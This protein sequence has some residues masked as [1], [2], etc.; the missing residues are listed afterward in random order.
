MSMQ[1]LKRIS[2]LRAAV[3]Q[4]RQA[5]ASIGL[6]PTMGALH[7]GHGALMDRAR[8]ESGFVVVT[9]FV[10]P[11][12]FDRSSDYERYSR[13]LPADLEFCQARG[14]ALVFAP[15]PDEIY[16][17]PQRVF[18]EA[19]SLAEHLCG[20]HR[21]GHFR[22]VATVVTKLF[23]VV[24]PDRAY[25][26]EKDAQ[27]LAIIEALVADL[28]MPITIV[29]V[30]TVR[31]SDGLA[32]S[33]RNTRLSAGER[34]QAAALY[35]ALRAVADKIAA[36]T[37]P[38]EAKDAG[39]QVLRQEPAIRVE[40]L[41]IVDARSMQRVNAIQGTVRVAAAVWIGET[42]LIDN[43]S[44]AMETSV[45]QPQLEIPAAKGPGARS[46]REASSQSKPT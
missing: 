8:T 21:P 39:S 41:E 36:G 33:S 17:Y 44:I 43:I 34:I 11:I 22:G 31:E 38:A 14:A 46:T 29:P 37:G 12:Q 24:Q 23:N 28:N 2:E 15:E 40:Y 35:R 26:G 18:V 16:P 13:N 6:V 42:R 4:A 9:I 27:Q 7:E 30:P 1:V 19:P 25:F 5:G 10:N 3:W 45:P 32:I 20:A